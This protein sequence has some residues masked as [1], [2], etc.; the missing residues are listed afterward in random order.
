[1]TTADFIAACFWPSAVIAAFALLKARNS[2]AFPIILKIVIWFGLAYFLLVVLWVNSS[3][4]AINDM[5]ALLVLF[6]LVVVGSQLRAPAPQGSWRDKAKGYGGMIAIVLFG[7]II[8]WFFGRMLVLDLFTSR[9]V[10]EGRVQYASRT[11]GRRADYIVIIAG[12]TVK[13]TAPL[14]ER[15]QQFRPKVRVEVG[16][17][18]NY[19]YE[20]EYLAN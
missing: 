6:G 20:I 2:A 11:S 1:M 17:G 18:S 16:R 5:N 8:A 14:Y 19:V 7:S 10:I 3:I 12:Q 13:V 15:L 4:I 9:L